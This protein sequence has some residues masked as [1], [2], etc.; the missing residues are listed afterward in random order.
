[1]SNELRCTRCL[2]VRDREP[3][4]FVEQFSDSA[5]CGKCLAEYNLGQGAIKDSIAEHDE[6]TVTQVAVV[7]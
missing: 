5:W 1:M 3:V 2:C 6:P 7:H 4:T